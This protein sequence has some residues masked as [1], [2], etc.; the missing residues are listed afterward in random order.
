[1]EHLVWS[2]LMN[3][4]KRK[5][6][7]AGPGDAILILHLVTEGR[8]DKVHHFDSKAEVEDYIREIGV[9][10]TAFMPGGYM[11]NFPGQTINKNTETGVYTI[12]LPIPP[13][14]TMPL[15]DHIEDTGKF[16]KAILMKPKQTLGKQIYGAQDYYSMERLAKEFEQVKPVDGKGAMAIEVPHDVYKGFLSKAGM[17]PFVQ[18]ELLQ[19]FLLN[20]DPGYYGGA[21]LEESQAIL[22]E[23]L[24]TWKQHLE[25]SEVIKDLK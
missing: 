23:P 6:V 14:T 19:N 25:K 11:A 9:P 12:A 21:S 15:Y 8:L 13:T 18:E 7:L 16:V 17:P 3:I 1:M 5:S 20:V 2:S 24:T 4:S 10:Y 22:D